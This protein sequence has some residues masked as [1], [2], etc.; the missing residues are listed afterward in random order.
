MREDLPGLAVE[1][2]LGDVA[3]RRE[4]A[5][6]VA[7]GVPLPRQ[8]VV[9]APVLRHAAVL[10]LLGRPGVV[11]ADDVERLAIRREPHRVRAV[12]AAALDRLELLHLVEDI[13]VLAMT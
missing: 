1:V 9:L 8:E 3:A 13:I 6:G 4:D 7:V 2:G 12:L 11:A 10:E 5:A